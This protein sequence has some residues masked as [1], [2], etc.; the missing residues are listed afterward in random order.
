MEE[1][2]ID[3][4]SSLTIQYQLSAPINDSPLLSPDHYALESITETQNLKPRRKRNESARDI[5]QTVP[6]FTCKTEST[7]LQKM[8]R[9][10]VFLGNPAKH[11]E[12]LFKVKLTKIIWYKLCHPNHLKAKLKNVTW[13]KPCNCTF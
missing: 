9:I 12:I 4:F 7:N 5:V 1:D 11:Q 13:Y 10:S 2:E 3:S 6:Y 8:L